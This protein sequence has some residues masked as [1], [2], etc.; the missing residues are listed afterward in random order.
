METPILHVSRHRP[1][2]TQPRAE[3]VVGHDHTAQGLLFD[4]RQEA[5]GIMALLARTQ[6]SV[7]P[8]LTGVR[9]YRK[10]VGQYGAGGRSSVNDK[11]VAV[12]GATGFLGRFVTNQLGEWSGMEWSR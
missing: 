9:G 10:Q 8:L 11:T 2:Y 1:Y 12:F 7:Q 6:R 3:E 5:R 4:P